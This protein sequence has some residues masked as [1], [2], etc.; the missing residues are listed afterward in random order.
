MRRPR[1]RHLLLALYLGSYGAL[2]ASGHYVI[3]NHGGMDWRREWVPR[4]LVR[5]YRSLTG[6]HRTALTLAGVAFVPCIV[7]D[8]LFWHRTTYDLESSPL[9]DQR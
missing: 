6:R 5:D 1:P 7:A 4:R 9:F 8:R 3:A 2:S